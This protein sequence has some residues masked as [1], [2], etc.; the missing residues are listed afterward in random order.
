MFDWLRK[1]FGDRGAQKREAPAFWQAYLESFQ[2]R[3]FNKKQPVET[4]SFVVFDTETTGLDLRKDH[5]LSIAALRVQAWQIDLNDRL[6]YFV[7]QAYRPEQAAV[8]IHGI[9]PGEREHSLSE[10]EAMARFLAFCGNSV[11]VGHHAA[12]DVAMVNE[13]LKNMGAGKLRNKLLDTGVLARRLARRPS[14]GPQ[15]PLGLDQL[16]QQYKIPM[17]DRHT[18]AGDTYIT[19]ILLIKLL[20]RLEMRGVRTLGGLLAARGAGLV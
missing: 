8:A 16:C 2:A 15:P 20:Y 6:E 17:S 13:A 11:L 7:H 12:F 10:A 19:A 1:Q 14:A 4:I 18:A 5:I 9:L 3:P